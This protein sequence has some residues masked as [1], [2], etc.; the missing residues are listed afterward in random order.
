VIADGAYYSIEGTE[1]LSQ[2]GITPVI[3][4]PSGFVRKG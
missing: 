4:P 3:P 2:A 1:A